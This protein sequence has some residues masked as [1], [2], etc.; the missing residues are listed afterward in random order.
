MDIQGE[1][2]KAKI[3]DNLKSALT[4]LDKAEFIFNDIENTYL[5]IK[6]LDP[7]VYPEVE[8]KYKRI[9]ALLNMLLDFIYAGKSY[10][11][12]L[13]DIIVKPSAPPGEDEE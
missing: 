5:A 8:V 11:D 3:R 7:E 9:E 13:G 4:K 12:E 1:N 6:D 10:M 2:D